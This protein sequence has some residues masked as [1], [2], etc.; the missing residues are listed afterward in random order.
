MMEFGELIVKSYL[1]NIKKCEMVETN[2]KLLKEYKKDIIQNQNV[3]NLIEIVKENFRGIDLKNNEGDIIAF[4]NSDILKNDSCEKFI[5]NRLLNQVE[6]DVVGYS[7]EEGYLLNEVAMHT[8]GLNYGSKIDN[9]EH[10]K[11]KILKMI[12]VFMG[13]FKG[14]K[15]EINFWAVKSAIEE[16]QKKIDEFIEALNS[17]LEKSEMS[18]IKVKMITDDEFCEIYEKVKKS[19]DKRS[20]N[21][22]E[23][24]L[25]IDKAIINNTNK[26]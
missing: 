25:N 23:R 15:G 21:E 24:F 7:K 13:Y 3:K 5:S 4:D 1:K 9:V 11:T 8:G 17:T 19:V 22:F 16:E 18:N 12:V 26:N 2:W 14:K 20:A 6:F 10:V